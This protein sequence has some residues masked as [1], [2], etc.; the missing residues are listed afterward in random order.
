[1]RNSFWR[2]VMLVAVCLVFSQ[3]VC[4]QEAAATPTPPVKVK[5]NRNQQIKRVQIFYKRDGEREYTPAKEDLYISKESTWMKIIIHFVSISPSPAKIRAKVE[6][7]RLCR[8]PIGPGFSSRV[9]EYFT[10]TAPIEGEDRPFVR[11]TIEFEIKL[12]PCA[13]NCIPNNAGS[14]VCRHPDRDHLGEGPYQAVIT[15]GAERGSLQDDQTSQLVYNYDFV[16]AADS[17]LRSP[18]RLRLLKEK[19]FGR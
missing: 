4:G 15:T 8:T 10:S 14:L 3:L 19:Y 6:L 5:D 13:T 16:T 18:A 1:M 9:T 11:D 7:R 2:L 12:E 17:D